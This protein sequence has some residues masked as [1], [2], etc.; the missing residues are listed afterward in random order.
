MAA[1]LRRMRSPVLAEL[2]A[3]VAPPACAA[4]RGPRP[5]ATGP[6]CRGCRSQLPWLRGP[7]CPRCALPAG[8]APCPARTAA[9]DRAW[10]PL[11]YAG[12][13]R[14][15]VGALKL[16]GAREVAWEMAGHIVATA[17]AGLLDGAVLVP[18]PAHPRR[19]RRRGFDPPAVLARELARRGAGGVRGALRRRGPAT[20][21]RGAGRSERLAPGRI[22]LEATGP[23]P[24]RVV[25]VD[26]VH[27]TG[28]TFDAAARA[29]RA[30]GA[31][32]ITALAYARTL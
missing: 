8:C 4:C 31:R 19:R 26:D 12:S 10:S 3:L 14:D 32:D 6:L 13:A 28:A 1:R 23:V 7:C 18:V 27:T 16:A 30:A 11:A 22:A 29:L 17:P 20:R 2:L 24:A 9:F 15:L 25:V 21:Q 5:A